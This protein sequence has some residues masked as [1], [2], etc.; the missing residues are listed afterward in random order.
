MITTPCDIK[1]LLRAVDIMNAIESGNKGK[2]YNKKLTAC[3][4]NKMK[5]RKSIQ[6]LLNS[7]NKF[8][9][10]LLEETKLLTS[11]EKDIIEEF[12]IHGNTVLAIS[13]KYYTGTSTVYRVI[14][15]FGDILYKRM[16]ND[17]E[18]EQTVNYLINRLQK[19]I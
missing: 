18:F 17:R 4:L 1:K 15:T 7:I 10:C 6:N 12:I 8:K 9:E 2:G 14:D 16:I 13:V 11:F 5:K 19:Y 3:K